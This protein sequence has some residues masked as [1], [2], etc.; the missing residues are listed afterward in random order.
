MLQ[1]KSSL[2]MEEEPLHSDH[3][4]P[5]QLVTI[6][7]LPAS[8]AKFVNFSTPFAFKIIAG[9]DNDVSANNTWRRS[10]YNKCT[11]HCRIELRNDVAQGSSSQFHFEQRR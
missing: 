2:R 8:R 3:R 9:H 6:A 10:G 5:T 1:S 7:L 11:F 4:A